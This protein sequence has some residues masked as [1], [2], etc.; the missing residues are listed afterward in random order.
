MERTIEVGELLSK[1]EIRIC[2]FLR[3]DFLLSVNC[4]QKINKPGISWSVICGRKIQTRLGRSRSVIS[5]IRK[6]SIILMT[7]FEKTEFWEITGCIQFPKAIGMFYNWKIEHP[8]RFRREIWCFIIE[9][10]CISMH[11]IYLLRRLCVL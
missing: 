6:I 4:G 11:V 7:F 9:Y 1:L 8:I 2:K 10:L 5:G 3:G